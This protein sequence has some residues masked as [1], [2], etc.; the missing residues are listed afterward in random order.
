MS[1]PRSAGISK[2]REIRHLAS[3][4]APSSNGTTSTFTRRWPHSSP[5]C[6]SR[7]QRNRR[8][9]LGVRDLRRPFPGASVGAFLFGRMGDLV[10][11]KYTFLVTIVVMGARHLASACFPPTRPSACLPRSC[12]CAATVPG[13]GAGRRIR[14]RR[15]LRRRTHV[16][17]D[18]G[19]ATS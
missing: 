8:A 5:L 14:R 18:R 3:S 13:P 12:W 4:L 6:S 10:G 19:Y 7:R 9:A 15:H 16:P 17:D 2:R 11:R 1:R